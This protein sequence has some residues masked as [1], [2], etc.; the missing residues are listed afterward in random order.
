MYVECV[1]MLNLI[2]STDDGKHRQKKIR[3]PIK[4]THTTHRI[5]H[6]HIPKG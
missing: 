4:K 5:T 1:R 3:T 6:T 2:I